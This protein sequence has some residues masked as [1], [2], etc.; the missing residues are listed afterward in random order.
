[1]DLFA[2]YIGGSHKQSLIEVHDIR[3]VIANSI[4]DTYQSLRQSWWG[5]P[6]SLHIDAWG[7][8]TSIKDYKICLAKQRQ[9]DS[10]DNLYFVNL[11]GYDPQQFTELHK[12]TFVIASDAISA[13]KKAMQQ[14]EQWMTP[15]RDNIYEVDALFN[16][17]EH[18]ALD[19]Y[20]L[21]IF[22]DEE[23]KQFEFV[24]HYNPIGRG[25]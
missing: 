12:N 14:V 7:K 11:G 23:S 21:H 15:H 1:M 13:K 3:F 10:N 5:E 16:L 8:L 2:I 25:S 22:A 6:S 17:S 18:V 19:N 20:Y 4:K 9:F 24:C